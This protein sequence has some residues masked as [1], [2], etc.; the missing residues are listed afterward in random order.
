VGADAFQL[1]RWGGNLHIP[2]CVVLAL[3]IVGGCGERDEEQAADFAVVARFGEGGRSPGQFVKPRAIDTDGH[4]LYVIDMTARVQRLDPRTGR[5]TAWWQLPDFAFGRPVGVSVGPWVDGSRVLYIP[6]THYHRVS[7]FRLPEEMGREPELLLRFGAYGTGPGQFIYP[8]DVA[9]LAGTG[10]GVERI[11]VSEYGGHDRISVF[12]PRGTFLFAFGAF[13]PEG[14]GDEPGGVYFNRPQSIAID[15]VRRELIVCDAANH[16]LGRFALDGTLLGWIGSPESA[17]SCPG[18]FKYPYGVA[19]AGDGTA[20]VCEYGN[21][22]VQHVD[23]AT[24]ASLG[25][26]GRSGRGESQAASPW[27]LALVGR[28][29]YVLDSGHNRVL[30]IDAPSRRGGGA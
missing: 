10:G 25:V 18:R 14:V 4:W 3:L 21:G 6:E 17:G 15:E 9:A 19:L 11:Y 24:G 27:G 26:Y 13:G 22:R 12:D 23:L 28:R 20:L 16:R 30:V 5:C 29:L 8:T 7:V 2:A 1:G